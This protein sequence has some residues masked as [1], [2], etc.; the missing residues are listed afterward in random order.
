MRHAI[1]GTELF[2][3]TR[4]FLFLAK[5][6]RVERS[7]AQSIEL[8]M[9]GRT[10]IDEAFERWLMLQQPADADDAGK[11]K[12]VDSARM[13]DEG[14]RERETA[15]LF[16]EHKQALSSLLCFAINYALLRN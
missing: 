5:G 8:M 6:S 15:A 9:I 16:H 4:N 11:N 10:L 13:Q 1:E 3:T 14:E 12:R 7:T 2:R